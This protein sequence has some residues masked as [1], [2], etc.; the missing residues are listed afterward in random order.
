MA[1]NSGLITRGVHMMQDVWKV[2]ELNKN[3]I[4]ETTPKDIK[5]SYLNGNTHGKTN[6]WAIHKPVRDSANTL[7]RD[8][9]E[10]WKSD[11]GLY[12]LGYARSFMASALYESAQSRGKDPFTYNPPRGVN[13]NYDEKFREG[14]WDGYWHF[15]PQPC[16]KYSIIGTQQNIMGI[17]G[18]FSIT[19]PK[20]FVANPTSEF[21]NKSITLN[22]IL[23]SGESYPLGQM[24][25]GVAV[26]KGTTNSADTDISQLTYYGCRTNSQRGKMNVTWENFGSAPY[27]LSYNQYVYY[28]PYFANA[29]V[30][31]NTI[32]NNG[33]ANFYLVP[34]FSEGVE[35]GEVY[36]RRF[37]MGTIQEQERRYVNINAY[38]ADLGNSKLIIDLSIF[39]GNDT[40]DFSRAGVQVFNSSGEIIWYTN[41][42]DSEMIVGNG[43]TW[44]RTLQVNITGALRVK[45]I[46][47]NDTRSV[48]IYVKTNNT[49]Q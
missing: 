6:K 41:F 27:S 21:A 9:K 12:G 1:N 19:L 17:G 14:D 39:N 10:A 40:F 5:L 26:W 7:Q 20:G 49:N 42:A 32:S 11:N 29:V 43:E 36:P 47:R 22:D 38:Y 18:T 25:F 16:G 44:E 45:F 8:N 31:E 13:A 4:F 33:A 30:N 24:Y 23:P 3:G 28:V 37:R 48:T 35:A 34:Y 46:V 15:A 2:L